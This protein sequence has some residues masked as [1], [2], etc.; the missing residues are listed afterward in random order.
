MPEKLSYEEFLKSLRLS[1]RLTVELVVTNA[2]GEILLL[3]RDKE[4]FKA[5]WHL[6]GSFLL[7]GEAI[8]DCFRRISLDEIGTELSYSDAKFKGLFENIQGDPRGH[9][10]HYVTWI[11]AEST[12]A[13]EYFSRLPEKTIPYQKDFLNKLGYQ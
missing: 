10:L 13:G 2:K 6:P 11:K 5:N 12:G 3:K 4:P 9:I 8:S 1:P 7:R